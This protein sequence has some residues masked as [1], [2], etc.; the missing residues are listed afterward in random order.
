M[1]NERA[2][3][4][5]AE[6]LREVYGSGGESYDRKAAARIV[7]AVLQHAPSGAVEVPLDVDESLV[8]TL[9]GAFVREREH[10]GLN[11]EQQA[12]GEALEVT[13]GDRL[14]RP[15][16]SAPSAQGVGEVPTR[17]AELE[18]RCRLLVSAYDHDDSED[19]VSEQVYLLKAQ[20]EG[21]GQGPGAQPKVGP[22]HFN[23]LSPAIAELLAL[24]SE[25]CGEVVQVVGK[26]LRHGT[27]GYHPSTSGRPTN[28]ELLEKELGDVLAATLLL[29]VTV[30]LDLR[31]VRLAAERKLARVGQYLHHVSPGD[32]AQATDLIAAPS[33]PSAQAWTRDGARRV[34]QLLPVNAT[35]DQVYE[36]VAAVF[37]TTAPQAWTR[38]MA[39]RFLCDNAGILPMQASRK[40]VDAIYATGLKVFG[41]TAP[42]ASAQPTTRELVEATSAA[43][44]NRDVMIEDLKRD[45]AAERAA[46]EA[47]KADLRGA[48]AIV[49]EDRQKWFDLAVHRQDEVDAAEKRAAELE[50]ELEAAKDIFDGGDK[51]EGEVFLPGAIQVQIDAKLANVARAEAA[52]A[53]RDTLRAELDS[54]IA[55]KWSHIADMEA[56]RKAGRAECEAELAKVREELAAA[57]A[58]VTANTDAFA[59]QQDLLVKHTDRMERAEAE[60]AAC[61]AKLEGLREACALSEAEASYLST[62]VSCDHDSPV[63]VIKRIQS[64]LQATQAEKPA[65][66]A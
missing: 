2:Q 55:G 14:R 65:K 20:L 8:A 48:L 34:W 27:S 46:H 19:A 39:E 42:V 11:T 58:D 23:G 3:E 17:D 31:E 28:A 50:R 62:Y 7:Q 6:I 45:L 9:Y 60:L 40:S 16:T 15:A 37:G 56:A 33:A 21:R 32:I 36:A 26:C 54:V 53:E 59:A 52:E 57:R 38:E 4:A 44:Q 43:V 24:L 22:S 13:L 18:H 35:P 64:A 63:A 25:E 41:T 5:V 51:S 49:K 10:S 47:T 61:R 1:T 30:R 12:L 29:G 66:H